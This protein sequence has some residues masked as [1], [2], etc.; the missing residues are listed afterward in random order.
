MTSSRLNASTNNLMRRGGSLAGKLVLSLLALL[1]VALPG[2]AEAKRRIVILDFEGPKAAQFRVDVERLVK[3]SY[4]V[5]P[6][7]KWN[8]AAEE[9]D[10]T[11]MSAK[12]VK[13]VAKRLNVDGIISGKVE[14]R[15]D[16]YIIRLKVREGT[17]GE[18]VGSPVD[19]KTG[20][21][22][23][24]GAATRE[25]K[26]ELFDNLDVLDTGGGG[27]GDD[28]EEEEEEE[29]PR[30]FV[31]RSS[32]DDDA[33]EEEEEEEEKPAKGKKGTKPVEDDEDEVAE[34]KPVKGK[35]GKPA[36]EDE[37]V[38]ETKPVKGKKEPAM[39][40]EPKPTKGKKEPVAV[41]EEPKPVKGKKEPAMVEEPKPEAKPEKKPDLLAVKQEPDSESKP[42]VPKTKPKK[43]TK[44]KAKAKVVAS[45]DDLSSDGE[46][47]VSA[48]FEPLA[49]EEQLN[50]AHRAIDVAAGMSFTMRRLRYTAGGI[51]APA[52]PPRS[53]DSVPVAGINFDAEGYPLAFGHKNRGVLTNIGLTASFDRTFSIRTR[54]RYS[55]PGTGAQREKE[56]QSTYQR[57]MLGGIYRHNLGSPSS[58]LVVTG[59]FRFGSQSFSVDNGGLD[60]KIVDIPAVSYTI[61]EPSAGIKYALG[62]KMNVG[63]EVGA[64]LMTGTGDIQEMDQ[65]GAATVTAFEGEAFFDYL[66]TDKIFA[67]AAFRAESIGFK[68]K[69]YGMLSNNR[70]GDAEQ[71]VTAAR[72]S[73]YGG[74]ITAGYLF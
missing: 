7:D 62:R 46:D 18:V 35:K 71:D 34:T 3:K 61:F 8:S 48:S 10:A 13:K 37:E 55:D 59:S 31:K 39:V 1:L 4:Q 38:A 2:I 27:G 49:S 32:S 5:I 17:T 28:E 50:I 63:A 24:D 68:F 9:M 29:K 11:G 22:R 16:E 33:E 26:S 72:D 66:V 43:T 45:D 57:F 73:Y 14:K 30:K 21:A 54:L 23:L 25:I 6:V 40:E 65:Y 58:P 51:Q 42:F 67:R 56:L 19:A 12:D 47:G 53:Y 20:G 52:T 74:A 15:R 70:D 41:V 64:L 36:E 44:K 60:Q 69:G